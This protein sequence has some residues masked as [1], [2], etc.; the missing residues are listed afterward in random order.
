MHIVLIAPPGA[1]KGTQAA[2]IAA[3]YGL[4]H[5][6]SGE[7]LRRNVAERTPIG[8]EVEHILAGGDLVP[9]S[10][11]LAML[12]DPVIEA[13]DHGGYILDGFPRTVLQA[14]E[15]REIAERLGVAPDVALYL[16]A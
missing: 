5:I 14:E 15:A 13:S 8:V 1:G 2:R 9:D 11:V 12:R 10:V 16:Q 3:R 6:S 7:L 4:R